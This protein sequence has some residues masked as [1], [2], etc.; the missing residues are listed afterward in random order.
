[1]TKPTK[2][3]CAQ[4]RLRSAWA[5]AQSDQSLLSAWRKLGPLATHWVHSKDSDQTVRMPNLI[6]VF[7]RRTAT[8]LVLSWGGSNTKIRF[9]Y[10][11]LL[12]TILKSYFCILL[13]T[14]FLSQH[15]FFLLTIQYF[16]QTFS[17]H[18]HLRQCATLLYQSQHDKTNRMTSVP[19]EDS[20]QPGHPPSLIREFTVVMKKPWVI[21]YP[22]STQRSLWSD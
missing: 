21:S 7:A 6:W 19:R 4:R 16:K 5:S 17:S 11:I 18:Y 20:D 3:V 13:W 1:M 10:R 15:L 9:L 12:R 8:L 14:V 22:W 2:W